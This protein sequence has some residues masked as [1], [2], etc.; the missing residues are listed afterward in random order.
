MSTNSKIAIVKEDGT[1]EAIWCHWDGY[2]THCGRI[3]HKHYT[4]VKKVRELIAQGNLDSIA[5]EIGEKYDYP[6]LRENM[7]NGP[8]LGVSSARKKL[9]EISKRQCTFYARDINEVDQGAQ[10]FTSVADF[11]EHGE[12]YNYLFKDGVWYTDAMDNQRS[13]TNPWMTVKDALE[14]EDCE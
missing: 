6:T 9:H 8:I 14:T 2:P 13:M 4:A 12:S 10:T 1:V 7:M 3:L 11:L 5:P